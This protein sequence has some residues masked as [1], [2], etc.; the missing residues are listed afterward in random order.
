[1]ECVLPGRTAV[2][3][4]RI[5]SSPC[6]S[7]SGWSKGGD[8]DLVPPRVSPS[9]EMLPPT[10]DALLLPASLPPQALQPFSCGFSS[11]CA[12]RGCTFWKNGEGQ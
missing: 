4:T 11:Y 10:C 1:M 2:L 7:R 3:H 5:N 8:K 6:N 9:Q 12:V